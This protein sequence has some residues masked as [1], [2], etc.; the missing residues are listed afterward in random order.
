MKALLAIINTI[1][2]AQKWPTLTFFDDKFCARRQ[3][4]KDRH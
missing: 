2:Y 3:M 1:D 4:V